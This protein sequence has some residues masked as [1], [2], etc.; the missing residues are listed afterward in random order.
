V[1]ANPAVVRLAAVRRGNQDARLNLGRAEGNLLSCFIELA[2]LE[3]LGPDIAVE[4][5]FLVHN[6]LQM[7][8]LSATE[9]SLNH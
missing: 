5:D 6:K 7:R 8:S 1:G 3:F 9:S 4:R 2:L